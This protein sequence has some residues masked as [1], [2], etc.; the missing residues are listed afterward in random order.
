MKL[1]LFNSY[2][3]I[4]C[5]LC[6]ACSPQ[7]RI[8]RLAE[9]YNLYETKYITLRDTV[10]IPAKTYITETYLDTSGRFAYLGDKIAYQG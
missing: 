9:K 10:I 8:A 5:V 2:L 6:G 4:L 7:K 3:I 1:R